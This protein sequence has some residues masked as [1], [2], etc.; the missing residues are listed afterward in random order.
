[1]GQLAAGMFTK[2]LAYK[3]LDWSMVRGTDSIHFCGKSRDNRIFLSG[4]GSTLAG[5]APA[6]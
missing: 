4:E 2:G 3:K 1:M 6:V 5:K